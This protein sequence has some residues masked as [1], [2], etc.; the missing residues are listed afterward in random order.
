MSYNAIALI[1]KYSTEAW[2]K[3]YKAESRSAILDGNKD[4]IKFV[5]AKTVKIAKYSSTGLGNYQR[6]NVPVAGDYAGSTSTEAGYGYGY[7]QGAA[8]VTW[9]EFTIANDRAVQL[10]I[11]LFDDEE[12]GGLAVAMATTE[13][14]R[15]TVIPEVDA[16]VFSKI[17]EQSG[18][19]SNEEIKL[20]TTLGMGNNDGPI[21]AL[22]KAFLVLEENEVPAEDQVI[23]CSPSFFNKLR[24]TNELVRTLSQS[25]YAKNVKFTVEEYEGRPI[26]VVP[27]RRFRTKIDLYPTGGYGWQ[28]GSEDI[29]FIVCAKSAVYHVTKYDKVRV[30][31]PEAV[32]D[33]DGYKVNVRV[34][35][36]VFVPDNKR[37]AI[38]THVSGL[39]SSAT[40]NSTTL[41]L[42]LDGRDVKG[43]VLNPGNTFIDGLYVSATGGIT[44]GTKLTSISDAVEIPALG[45]LPE[46][47]KGALTPFA[48]L[49][50][51]VVAVGT[52][53]TV[54]AA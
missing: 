20:P 10:R 52:Q 25:E 50:G 51:K 33:F 40:M 31:K 3:V 53:I 4:L 47:V 29:D 28:A 23:F 54:A 16:Y 48:V 34:Y 43:Y 7:P 6:A 2:D 1:T 24:G 22:N 49:D 11:D 12:T 38:Y 41:T 44:L 36:D 18:T 45:T 13:E 30:I 37:C 8:S 17:A 27:K 42:R 46:D 21:A 14:S 15:T 26:I 19:I 39:A 9:E 32:Q 5:G 35:H